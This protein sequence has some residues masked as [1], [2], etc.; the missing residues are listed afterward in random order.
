MERD[1]QKCEEHNSQSSNTA[2]GVLTDNMHRQ[3]LRMRKDGSFNKY[4]PAA[5][6]AS[7]IIAEGQWIQDAE[8][9]KAVLEFMSGKGDPNG[10]TWEKSLYEHYMRPKSFSSGGNHLKDLLV[11]EAAFFMGMMLGGADLKNS[12]TAGIF[13][14]I[15]LANNLYTVVDA[16]ILDTG[17]L[18]LTAAPGQVMEPST[19]AQCDG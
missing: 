19:G 18:V 12:L 6:I 10:S 16:T 15:H 4:H 11:H 7:R 17:L 8:A 2:S 1:F 3:N 5:W 9:K 14:L 13:S